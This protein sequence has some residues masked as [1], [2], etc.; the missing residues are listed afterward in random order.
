MNH[1]P[2]ELL[3]DALSPA[4]MVGSSSSAL[5]NCAGR[6]GLK[7]YQAFLYKLGVTKFPKHGQ[8][9]YKKLFKKMKT[10]PETLV[11]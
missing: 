8:K 7:V 5:W 2:V 9:N 10:P 1:I 6:E 4:Y 3:V 11:Q